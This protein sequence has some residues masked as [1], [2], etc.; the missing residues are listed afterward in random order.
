MDELVA[1]VDPEGTVVG[2]ALRSVVR[3]DNLRHAATAVL[4][5]NSAGQI[6]V[7][8]RAATKDWAPSHH[9]A[10]A[11][12]ILRFGEDPAQSAVREVAEELGIQTAGLRSLGLSAYDDD[13]T[14]VVEH[15]FETT[16]D[17]PVRFA[18]GEVVS[19][20]WLTLAELGARLADPEWRFVPDT[21]QLLAGLVARGVGDYADLGWG[22]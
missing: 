19:G 13:T 6:Y 1:I 10:A 3:R 16:W 17:G 9:D 7:H 20:Q 18:D 2:S 22:A 4:V 14:R 5:R 12:G 15:V 11:G 8:L 21:R